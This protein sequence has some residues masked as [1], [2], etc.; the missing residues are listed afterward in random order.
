MVYKWKSGARIKG[1]AQASGEL[2][3]QLANTPD[4]LTA[5]T[6]LDANIPESAPLHSDYEW[7]DEIAAEKWRL[8]QSNQFINSITVVMF[9]EKDGGAV[10]QPR[11]FHITT[12]VHK[13][14]PLTAI[15]QEPTKY[16]ALLHN[17]LAELS[18]FERKYKM[19]KE[20]KPI[21]KAFEEV[22]SK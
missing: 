15:V 18:A 17:A 20:L 22:K 5:R 11:A 13:Y 8:Q 14:E 19:L 9:E 10:E 12:E 7:N 21:F 1:D 2:F 6:L 16:K 4:G 3:E